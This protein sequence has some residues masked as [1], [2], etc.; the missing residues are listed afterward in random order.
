[1]KRVGR[2]TIEQVRGIMREVEADAERELFAA[3]TYESFQCAAGR[4]RGSKMTIH[5]FMLAAGLRLSAGTC[6]LQDEEFD[7]WWTAMDGRISFHFKRIQDA[8]R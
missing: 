6:P 8:R 2:L 1:M 3:G 5:T 4:L 7:A